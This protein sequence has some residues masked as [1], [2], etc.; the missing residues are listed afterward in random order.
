MFQTVQVPGELERI[1]IVAANY[2]QSLGICLE[3]RHS[4]HRYEATVNLFS[5][6]VQD[7]QI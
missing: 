4:G 6:I 1:I 2:R 7:L 3:T 5:G